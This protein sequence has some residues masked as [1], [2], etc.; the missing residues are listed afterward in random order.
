MLS[1]FE[2]VATSV[3]DPMKKQTIKFSK[4]MAD[5]SQANYGIEKAIDGSVSNNNGWAVD[6]PTRKESATAIFVAASK[7]GYAGGT[8][9]KFRLRHEA[10]FGAHGICLLYTSPSPRDS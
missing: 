3:A 6:G 4:A 7:F 10:S 1:E 5:Y 8:N 9:L 2:L